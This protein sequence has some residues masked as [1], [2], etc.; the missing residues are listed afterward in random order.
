MP[1]STLFK[2]IAFKGIFYAFCLLL[3]R[4]GQRGV[5][6]GGPEDSAPPKVLASSPENNSINFQGKE[7][8]F[9]FDE[10]VQIK[11]FK[12]EFLISPPVKKDPSYKL[13]GK[14]LILTFDS[15]FTDNTTYTLYLGNAVVDFNKGNVL[16]SN[17][18]VFST[19]DVIDSLE[20]SGNII[21]AYTGKPEEEI[22]VHLYKNVADSAPQT[23]LPSYFTLAKKGKF[24]FK[25]LAAGTYRIF[26]LK[27]ENNNYI[28]D[29][30]NE[31]IAFWNDI[32]T[33][34]SDSQEFIFSTFLPEKTIQKVLRP[35]SNKTNE[36]VLSFNVPVQK[37]QISYL[38][39]NTPTDSI[40][41][42]WNP[43]HD[44]LRLLSSTFT[45][46]EKLSITVQIDTLPADTFNVK[47]G[48][49]AA[50]L[51]VKSNYIN[52]SSNNHTKPLELS[53]NV[54]ISKVPD[55]GI[56]LIL[57]E[58]TIF[59][60]SS[61]LS[62][63]GQKLSLN[64]NFKAEQDYQVII[65]PSALTSITGETNDTLKYSFSADKE[66]IYG[67]LLLNYSFDPNTKYI[68]TLSSGKRFQQEIKSTIPP[69]PISLAGLK[70]GEYQLSVVVDSDQNGKWSTGN[71]Q[72]KSL[73]EKVMIYK[74][75]ITIRENWDLEVNWV[76]E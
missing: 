23:T 15:A 58:D 24:N 18:F 62:D 63:N 69:K 28:N 47:I 56:Q 67:T 75:S 31:K 44:S 43:T 55:T 54:P 39:P 14:K 72:S 52:N 29:L 33:V 21:D 19:G 34:P 49:T 37:H 5:P 11:G 68:F 16:D 61:S 2:N 9:K 66:G 59:V 70:S 76:L 51:Q 7:I 32:I 38:T 41:E 27:D 53:F 64:Y 35:Y 3:V 74:E 40:F 4:C 20:F 8:T 10:Y 17:L 48:K 71:Y 6:T 73:P 46:G 36:I 13:S 22:L 65:L 30:P 57:N 25:N 12:Q 1:L 26:A 45:A 42:Y 50:V 60:T